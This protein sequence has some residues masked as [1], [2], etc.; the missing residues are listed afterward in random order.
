MKKIFYF[1]IILFILINIG[2]TSVK[3]Q[4]S[5]TKSASPKPSKTTT[6]AVDDLKERLATKVAELN[7]TER[8]AI[9]GTVKSISV[10]SF[11]VE[12]STKNLKIELNDDI[13]VYKI[14]GVKKTT[15]STDN[16][17]EDMDISIFGLYDGTLDL[18]NAKIIYIEPTP[19][20]T[21]VGSVAK[22]DAADY[23]LTLESST[24]TTNIIDYEKYTVS[25]VWSP[26][27]KFQ[28]LGFSKITQNNPI[29]TTGIQNIKD[30]SRYS[31]YRILTINLNPTEAIPKD[32]TPSATITKKP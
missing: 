25:E 15:L 12:T 24:G 5:A 7:T 6:T 23:S 26:S 14:D 30:K 18:M 8:R 29:V 22:V 32:A 4:S 27:Q 28:K 17:K 19:L 2:F 1:S 3:A 13:K 10:A 20:T 21:L 31:A 9:S 11:V 16:L